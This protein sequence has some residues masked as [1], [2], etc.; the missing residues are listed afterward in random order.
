MRL[1]SMGVGANVVKVLIQVR[2]VR[3][4]PD[5]GR[6]ESGKVGNHR[7]IACD[8]MNC[9]C[10]ILIQTILYTVLVDQTD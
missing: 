8:D 3:S 10:I 1:E 7:V 9:T 5:R 6:D 4:D 2:V